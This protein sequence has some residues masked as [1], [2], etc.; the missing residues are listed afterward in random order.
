MSRAGYTYLNQKP[1]VSQVTD[2][3]DPR[4]KDAH[5]GAFIDLNTEGSIKSVSL[6]CPDQCIAARECSEGLRR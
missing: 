5:I 4:L 6:S 3:R 1:P 2:E